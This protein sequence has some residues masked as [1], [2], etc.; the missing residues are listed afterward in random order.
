M[1]QLTHIRD[2]AE[3]RNP[4]GCPGHIQSSSNGTLLSLFDNKYVSVVRIS[5]HRKLHE[6]RIR[7]LGLSIDAD[8]RCET[9]TVRN[10]WRATML[11]TSIFRF[12]IP[13]ATMLQWCTHTWSRPVSCS[14][15]YSSCKITFYLSLE[16]VST[17]KRTFEAKQKMEWIKK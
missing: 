6:E 4:E 9:E 12:W 3:E 1:N 11:W 7:R 14:R 16:F 15:G 2:C 8:I 17:D 5:N 13:L 10:S